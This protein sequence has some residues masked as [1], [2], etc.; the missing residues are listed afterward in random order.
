MTQDLQATRA[1]G[2]PAEPIDRLARYLS[3]LGH[4]FLVL[5][6]SIGAVSALRGGDTRAGV[7]LAVLFIVISAAI[8]VGIRAG[9]FNDFDVS[10][11]QRR[12]GF[13]VLITAGTV[14]LGFWLRDQ[15]EALH[16]CVIAGALL[17]A[18]GLLNRWTKASLHTAFSLYAA[19]FWGA[20]SI[21]AGLVVLVLAAAVG[22][23]RI[24]LG[25]HS[26]T[27]V[28]VGAGLGLVAGASLMSFA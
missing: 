24:R 28:L 2:A 8:V 7:G 21:S 10:E 4:P 18:C 1:P 26:T 11:R 14:A 6:A 25:R 17:I 23:S 19:G 27:E 13:Y 20:W 16:T 12:P 22:W 3:V 15:P 9:R 5:P